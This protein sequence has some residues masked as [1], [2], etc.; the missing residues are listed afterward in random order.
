MEYTVILLLIIGSFIPLLYNVWLCNYCSYKWEKEH[1]R[2]QENL[3][4]YLKKVDELGKEMSKEYTRRGLFNENVTNMDN[5]MYTTKN[6]GNNIG[7]GVLE[8]QSNVSR[9]DKLI[10][11]ILDTGKGS[12]YM[13]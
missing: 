8:N 5:R 6:E 3:K 11:K 7:I 10:R 4:D 12:T 13:E 9:A 2:E 1:E